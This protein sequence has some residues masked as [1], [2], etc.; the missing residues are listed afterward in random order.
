[1]GWNEESIAWRQT[2]TLFFTSWRACDKIISL[3][4]CCLKVRFAVKID[5]LQGQQCHWQ[6]GDPQPHPHPPSCHR[7]YLTAK[8]TEAHFHQRQT[9]EK[10]VSLCFILLI[11]VCER[12]NLKH[13]HS[14][15]EQKRIK[16]YVINEVLTADP[17]KV[18]A[19]CV[20]PQRVPF[21]SQ[22]FPTAALIRRFK[23]LGKDWSGL[24]LIRVLFF[25]KPDRSHCSGSGLGLKLKLMQFPLEASCPAKLKI[26]HCC[27]SLPQYLL[28]WH[29]PPFP[30]C[31]SVLSADRCV[32]TLILV[33]Y[34]AATVSKN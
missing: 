9:R 7:L 18:E 21:S 29:H 34:K 5:A 12:L 10:R 8:W 3:T 14:D 1:M 6:S 17:E 23:S 26:H 19:I 2:L 20:R 13:I 33:H 22:R 11:A 30:T 27:C 4:V 16:K 24:M 25:S 32:L 15:W 31:I 28:Q